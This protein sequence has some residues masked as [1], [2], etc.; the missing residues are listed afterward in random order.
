MQHKILLIEDNLL[1]ISLIRIMLQS[2]A[3]RLLEA[4]NEQSAFEIAVQEAP[5]L[6]ILDMHRS[7]NAG[8]ALMKSLKR[9]LAPR[10]IPVLALVDG[11][12][13]TADLCLASGCAGVVRKP[14]HRQSLLEMVRRFTRVSTSATCAEV[15]QIPVAKAERKRVLI[16][17]DNQDLRRIFART[18]DQRNFQVDTA[19][20]GATTLQNLRRGLP[21]VLILDVNMPEAS[22]FDVLRHVRQIPGGKNV[23][24][25]M[26]TGN[27]MATH[28]PEAEAADLLL[29]KPVNIMDLVTLAQRLT[30]A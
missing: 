21:D 6:I 4:H 10:H 20:D 22:G 5:D 9:A 16:A 12:T 8:F 1:V 25:I 24:V 2:P 30:S 27:D 13:I 19:D 28:S 11:T 15:Q 26:V 3:Y 14:V 18:F 17:D 23:K 7:G 29:I